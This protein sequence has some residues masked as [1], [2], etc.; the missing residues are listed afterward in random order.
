MPDIRRA[1]NDCSEVKSKGFFR[2]VDEN[3]VNAMDAYCA[4]I[5]SIPNPMF[6][7]DVDRNLVFLNTACLELT[8][9]K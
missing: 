2:R 3:L 5:N 7:T 9:I 8:G 4:T 6:I 1:F